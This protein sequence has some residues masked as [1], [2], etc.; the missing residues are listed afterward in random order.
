MQAV[1]AWLVARPQNAVLALA[2]TLLLTYLSFLSGVVLMLLILHKGPQRALLDLLLASALLTAV[3]AVVK[4]PISAVLLGAM[5]IWAPALLLGI[6]LKKTRSLT[7]TL[8]LSVLIATAGMLVFYIAVPDAT[9]MSRDVLETIVAAWRELGMNEQADIIASDLD[10]LAE[11]VPLIVAMTLWLVQMVVCVLG[12]LLYRQ[13]PGGT[14]EF[15]RFRDLNLGRV[16]AINMALA[17]VIA[18]ASDAIWLQNIALLLYLVFFVQGLAVVHWLYSEGQ[19]PVIGIIAMYVLMPLLHYFMLM[20]LA[21]FGYI[22]T[23]FGLRRARTH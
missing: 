22:D 16:I 8:Q 23:W 13:L 12:Y 6:L 4:A 9:A 15:G 1:A 5:I 19:L 18:F 17:S 2:T 21:L 7:L 10:N 11:R 3:A 14:A 20:G